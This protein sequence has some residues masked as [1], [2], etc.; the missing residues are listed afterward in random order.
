MNAIGRA[1]GLSDE[2]WT[3]R[4]SQLAA[5]AQAGPIDYVAMYLTH[6]DKSN[7]GSFDLGFSRFP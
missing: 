4:S 1:V 3:L 7:G 6:G 5:P 2:P